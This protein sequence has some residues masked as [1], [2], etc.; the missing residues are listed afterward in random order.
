MPPWNS[1]RNGEILLSTPRLFLR[2]W[3]SDDLP[4]F[5]ELNADPE[6]MCYLG[7]ELSTEQA[8]ELAYDIQERFLQRGFGMLPVERREDGA[9]LGICGI[10]YTPWYP[11]EEIGW[12]FARAYWGKG[13]ATES[14]A[15]WMAWAFTELG[16]PRLISVTDV[17]NAR[18]IAVM[19]RLG[20]TYD[21]EADLEDD[22][23]SGGERFRAVVHSIT[24]EQWRARNH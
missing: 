4:A 3:R 22:P 10:N 6:V 24:A 2:S 18:S 16:A 14:A 5:A 7:T 9:F 13:Y 17:P 11:D 12:R 19:K 23:D 15:A 20:M 8:T 21:H 1:D